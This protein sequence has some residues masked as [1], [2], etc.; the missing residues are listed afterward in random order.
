MIEKIPA[1]N[2]IHGDHNIP[3]ELFDYAAHRL[4]DDLRDSPDGLTLAFNV[5]TP[6]GEML[7]T[8]IYGPCMG[9]PVIVDA[10]CYW[11]CR[12]EHTY[13]SRIISGLPQR[14]VGRMS[15]AGYR[16]GKAITIRT[17]YGGPVLSPMEPGDPRCDGIVASRKFWAEHALSDQAAPR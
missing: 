7:Y 6:N 5:P 13:R 3:N 16:T 1:Y 2:V 10:Q 9:D 15:Y 14:L 8:P 11:G 4:W 12:G 17:V